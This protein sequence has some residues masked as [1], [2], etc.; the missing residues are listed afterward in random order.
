MSHNIIQ[1]C[2]AYNMV[3]PFLAKLSFFFYFCLFR[4]FGRIFIFNIHLQVII[5]HN[6][7]TIYGFTIYSVCVFL[8]WHRREIEKFSP[9]R[10]WYLLVVWYNLKAK[11][12][13]ITKKLLTL[14]L[15]V[16]NAVAA[17]NSSSWIHYYTI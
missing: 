16:V 9:P 3:I 7:R 10:K 6:N 2:Y 1:C 4:I 11:T 17:N 15:M 13:L 5:G 12:L 8:K 14:L